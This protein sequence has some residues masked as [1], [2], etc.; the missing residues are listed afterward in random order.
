MTKRN[1]HVGEFSLKVNG[2][3][4]VLV[5]DWKAIARAQNELGAA[6]LVKVGKVGALSTDEIAKLLAI[7]FEKRHPE[8]DEDA[9]MDASPV[10]M[11]ALIA[12]DQALTYSYFGPGGKETEK[13]KPDAATAEKA[14]DAK[15]KTS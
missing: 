12:I 10:V 7:G 15:K 14:K 2:K 13:K 8:L 5:Y 11:D 3:D 4:C 6:V 1:P 9:I